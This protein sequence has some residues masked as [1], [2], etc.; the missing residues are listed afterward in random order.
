MAGNETRCSLYCSSAE[1]HT[2]SPTVR[3]GK[4]WDDKGTDF[5]RWLTKRGEK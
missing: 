2:E 4:T 3:R 5:V 1:D